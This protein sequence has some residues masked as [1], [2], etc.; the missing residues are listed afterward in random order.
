MRSVHAQC[1]L[2]RPEGTLTQMPSRFGK[3]SV[4]WESLYHA[5]HGDH[6]TDK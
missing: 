3:S 4:K 6:M 2:C 1:R 5:V